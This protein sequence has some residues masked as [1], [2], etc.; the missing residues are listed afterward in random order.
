MAD[1]DTFLYDGETDTEKV[2]HSITRHKK[3]I[4]LFNKQSG[5]FVSMTSINAAPYLNGE[6]YK[7]KEVEID[8]DTQ[9]WEGNYDSGSVVNV[10]EAPVTVLESD[11][12]R[13]AGE[14]IHGHIIGTSK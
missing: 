1:E 10:D 13:K 5:E 8:V 12:D 7:W 9:R 14:T 11:M 6:L 2:L 4:A 3:Q